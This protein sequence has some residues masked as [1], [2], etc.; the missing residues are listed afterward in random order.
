[1][2]V[3]S[4]GWLTELGSIGSVAERGE[5]IEKIKCVVVNFRGGCANNEII[6]MYL[7]VADALV[8][9]AVLW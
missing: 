8:I 6:G 3:N 4:P 9:I 5:D 7:R 1:M 2:T